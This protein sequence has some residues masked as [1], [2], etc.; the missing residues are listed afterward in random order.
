M[1]EDVGALVLLFVGKFSLV[2]VAL[3][4]GL[5]RPG[6]IGSIEEAVPLTGVA[7]LLIGVELVLDVF[8]ATA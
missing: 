7:L 5:A 2:N 1:T 4:S 8:S 6:S 3:K